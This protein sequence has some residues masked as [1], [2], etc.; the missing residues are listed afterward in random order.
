MSKRETIH[1]GCVLVGEAGLLI[2]GASGSGKSTLAREVVSLALR[3]GRFGRLVSDDRTLL[4]AHHGRLL[5]RPV[6]PLGGRI[7][8]FGLGIVRQPFES[9]AVVRLVADL[10]DAPA[11]YPEEEDRRVEIC[12][13]MVPR[14]RMPAGASSP[15]VALACLSG[16]CDTV[17]TL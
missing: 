11:R 8:V 14:I 15:D 4:E 12:G 6:V 3:A 2:R 13:V 5:A 17:V 16:V 10:S 7:E 9:A 1:A